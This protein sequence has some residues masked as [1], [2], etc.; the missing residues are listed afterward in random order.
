M[1]IPIN[2]ISHQAEIAPL[3]K[4]KATK[5]S[6]FFLTINTNQQYR[7]DQ[8][9]E[10]DRNYFDGVINNISNNL[11]DYVKD[12]DNIWNEHNI[13]NVDVEYVCELGGKKQSLHAHVLIKIE[14]NTNIKLDFDKIKNKVKN[15][16]GLKSIHF[17]N[18]M[19][20]DNNNNVLNYINKYVKN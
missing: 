8:H 7:N 3:E 5:H 2:V 20:R 9:L 14:H 12:S 13:K 1:D 17:K 6:N 19:I 15:D 10:S 11:K 16:L 4:N 18:Y